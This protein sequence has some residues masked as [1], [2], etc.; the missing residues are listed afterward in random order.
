MFVATSFDF[1]LSTFTT[2]SPILPPDAFRSIWYAFV[3][4]DFLRESPQKVCAFDM[5]INTRGY[6][7]KLPLYRGKLNPKVAPLPAG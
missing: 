1:P 3:N 6:T 7:S 5:S 4:K 2:M